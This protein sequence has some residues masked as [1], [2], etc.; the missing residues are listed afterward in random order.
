MRSFLKSQLWPAIAILLTFTVIAGVIY[1]VAVTAVAQVVFPGQANG[2]MIVVDGKTRRSQ[3]TDATS[4]AN[5]S[6]G[7]T[8]PSV[9]RGRPLSSF[10]TESSSAWS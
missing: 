9:C 6:D 10:A 1:P 2:S 7:F 4:L 3:V 8:Q 5:A